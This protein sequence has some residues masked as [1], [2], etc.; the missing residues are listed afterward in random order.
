MWRSSRARTASSAAA[1]RARCA[2]AVRP[3][4]RMVAAVGAGGLSG[5][6][7]RHSERLHPSKFNPGTLT[8]SALTSSAI[9]SATSRGW[10]STPSSR[11]APAPTS[12]R[13]RPALRGKGQGRAHRQSVKLV[14]QTLAT[15]EYFK[16]AV[17]ALENPVGRI[18][19]LGGLPP[20][21]LSFDPNDLGDT[22]TKKT[23]LWG[24]F[25]ADLPVA[26]VEPTEG[27]KM[28]TQ[29]RRQEP[30]HEER[31]ERDAGGLQLRL[32]HRQQRRRSPGSGK[33]LA[34][35]TGSTAR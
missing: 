18:E 7:L 26:P 12:H 5:L 23:L 30:R 1:T 13:R 22:Y 20:W 24:R 9:G 8:T 10:T 21:R 35:M 34:S 4:R 14:Q 15:I 11:P 27:S 16:P 6:P 33:S 25:N 31:A 28:H 32:L 17:W 29:V 2:V 19:K 3:L